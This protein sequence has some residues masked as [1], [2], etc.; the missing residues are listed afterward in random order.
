[1]QV[2]VLTELAL[3]PQLLAAVIP[4]ATYGELCPGSSRVPVC[5]C[6]LSTHAVEIPT[7]TVVGQVA[8][9][10]KYCQWST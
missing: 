10:T 1:M 8:P 3:G 6:N 7:K 9:P 5:L 4:T 2:H